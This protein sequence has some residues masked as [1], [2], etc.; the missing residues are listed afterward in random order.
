MY[1]SLRVSAGNEVGI[2]DYSNAISGT[3]FDSAPAAPSNARVERVGKTEAELAWET[4]NEDK[5]VI[6]YYQVFYRREGDR[7]FVTARI[8]D[9]KTPTQAFTLRN[10]YS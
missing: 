2:S 8:D 10:L 7:D 5:G 4:P 3:P 9:P 6:R 1:S